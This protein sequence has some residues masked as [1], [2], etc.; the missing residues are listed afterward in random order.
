MIP[1]ASCKKFCIEFKTL[2]DNPWGFMV[3]FNTFFFSQGIN[4]QQALKMT[5]DPLQNAI[6][7]AAFNKLNHFYQIID[8]VNEEKLRLQRSA[9]DDESDDAG[10]EPKSIDDPSKLSKETSLNTKL[11][12]KRK[13]M[14]SIHYCH[15]KL[16]G[17]LDSLK[18]SSSHAQ[19]VIQ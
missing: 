19:Q 18:D 9:A 5:S 2:L 1:K 11:L 12:N 16:V 4:I 14:S 6:N 13:T 7:S 8:K 3:K 15:P 10:G 17:M